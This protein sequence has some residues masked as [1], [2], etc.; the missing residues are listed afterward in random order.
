[1]KIQKYLKRLSI[2]GSLLMGMA[3]CQS[4]MDDSL[5]DPAG[6]VSEEELNRDGFAANAFF[7]VMCDYAYPTGNENIYNREMS[8]LGDCYGRYMVMATDKFKGANYITYSA[9]D[10]WLGYIFHAEGTMVNLHAA[11]NQIRKVT[12]EVGVNYAWAQILRVLGMQRL[13][14]VYG[15]IPYTKVAQGDITTAYDTMEEAYHAMFKDL[16]DAINVMTQY[17][18]ANPAARTMANFDPIYEGDFK[19]WVKFANSLKLRMAIR[20]RFADKDFAQEMAEEAVTHAI[21][22]MTSNEDNAFCL[23]T[24]NQLWTVLTQWADHCVSADLTA[25]MNGFK[26]ARLPKYV[27]K[28]TKVYEKE[29]YIG[30]RAGQSYGDYISGPKLSRMN[31]GEKD[32]MLWMCAAET[33]FNRAEGAMI[34]WAMGGTVKDLYEEGVRLSFSQWGAQGVD[35]Y[36]NDETS[37]QATYTDPYSGSGNIQP[38]STITIKWKDNVGEEEKLERLI[39]QKWIALYPLGQEAWS[40]YRR[41]GYPKFF[42]VFGNVTPNI[43]V[44]NRIPFPPSEFTR[45]AENVKEAIRKIGGDGYDVKLWWQRKDK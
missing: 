18:E 2:V 5:N 36:L 22:V 9:N 16:T 39:T 33:A 21:G 31:T 26:D 13:V 3:L 41:T 27:T 20:I 14:D 34:G 43:P 7:P 25:Y 35:A 12:G 42:P 37:S 32:R 23:G 29:P 44:A 1:M 17:V 28:N 10:E 45:N 6:R 4:C 24:K 30:M 8:I 38:V 11:W 19:K 15:A 40:E